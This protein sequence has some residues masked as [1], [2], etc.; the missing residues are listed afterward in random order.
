MY[1][2]KFNLFT[3]CNVLYV[4]TFKQLT[5]K[6]FAGSCYSAVLFMLALADWHDVHMHAFE[7]ALKPK[8]KYTKAH[9]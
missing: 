3:L 2:Q 7:F 5:K 6:S 4:W 8:H 1:S 9:P